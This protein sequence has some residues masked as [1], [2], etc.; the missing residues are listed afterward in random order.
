MAFLVSDLLNNAASEIGI[1]AAGTSLTSNDQAL[2]LNKFNRLRDNWNAEGLYLYATS[3][4][5]YTLTPN[6]NPHT[7]GPSGGDFTLSSVPRPPRIVQ[8]DLVLT[9]VSPNIYRPLKLVDDAWWMNNPVPTLATQ[10]PFYLYYNEDW[11][12]GKI[13]LWPVPATAY[14]L[15]LLINSAFGVA[16]ASDTFTLPP[17]YEDA[18][19][20]SLA[21][22]MCE[23][24]VNQP[25]SP[26]LMMRAAQARERI[27]LMNSEIPTLACDPAANSM[28]SKPR[29]SIANFLSG[30][31]N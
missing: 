18:V 3:L 26:S 13:Y 2:A 30:F 16:A 27:R 28:D 1:L 24:F 11:P 6:H 7:I 12:L 31:F 15:R 22:A 9:D 17:G 20:L 10:I 8:A 29:A 19:T 21:E 4:L 5:D 23:A 14:G 25:P